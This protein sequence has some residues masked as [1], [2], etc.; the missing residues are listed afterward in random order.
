MQWKK[1]FYLVKQLHLSGILRLIIDSSPDLRLWNGNKRLGSY[2][3][4]VEKVLNP[5]V[6]GEITCSARLSAAAKCQNWTWLVVAGTNLL[7]ARRNP[8]DRST[9][10]KRNFVARDA[11]IFTW[12]IADKS[13]A[14]SLSLG[15]APRWR[16]PIEDK[17]FAGL[18]GSGEIADNKLHFADTGIISQRNT[19]GSNTVGAI[20][21]GDNRCFE[22]CTFLSV[23]L[24]QL[25]R[26]ECISNRGRL[27]LIYK[28]LLC[29]SN[30][31]MFLLC[32]SSSISFH[33]IEV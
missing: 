19:M 1:Y 23:A 2:K 10:E 32:F 21:T 30:K 24:G 28:R 29:H 8:W 15:H 5:I 25:Q 4:P 6:F 11:E 22:R 9:V 12:I 14:A 27:V 16:G 20:N 33:R 18:I 3:V 13:H 7:L 26:P 17:L 31:T